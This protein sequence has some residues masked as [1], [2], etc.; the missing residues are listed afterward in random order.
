MTTLSSPEAAGLWLPLKIRICIDPCCPLCPYKK[1]SKRDT[2]SILLRKYPVAELDMHC[3]VS[4]L[5][6][7]LCSLSFRGS[8]RKAKFTLSNKTDTPYLGTLLEGFPLDPSS[9]TLL[10]DLTID[11]SFLTSVGLPGRI[12]IL[13]AMGRQL[14]TLVLVGKSVSGIFPAIRDYCPVIRHLRVDRV[15]SESSFAT[16]SST[17]LAS[18]TLKRVGFLPVTLRTVSPYIQR[19]SL[20]FTCR[21]NEEAYARF[22]KALPQSIEALDIE[23][24]SSS[25][26]DILRSLCVAVP[27]LKELRLVG[28]YDSGSVH[29]SSMS[30]FLTKCPDLWKLDISGSCSA[31]KLQ[32]EP[33]AV[34]CLAV[35]QNLTHIVLRFDEKVAERFPSLLARENAL[36]NIRLWEQKK[37]FADPRYWDEVEARIARFAACHPD[38]ELSLED[39]S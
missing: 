7:V 2:P 12:K 20:T 34:P 4:D 10:T 18:L 21:H 30:S 33:H 1:G 25:V 6:T 13:Q 37:W 17:F 19:L 31:L 16:Y 28:A 22:F 36:K 27:H 14:D 5:P 11:S 24:P 23:I 3:L 8:I 38:I 9:F 26:D 32:L 29:A 15:E 39:R 35:G